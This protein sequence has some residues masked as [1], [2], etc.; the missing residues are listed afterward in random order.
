M[1]R[2]QRFD[3]TDNG[4]A[5]GPHRGSGVPKS[6]R[7][8]DSRIPPLPKTNLLASDAQTRLKAAD[9]SSWDWARS[10]AATPS[11]SCSSQ[12]RTSGVARSTTCPHS[13][14]IEGDCG[15]CHRAPLSIERIR[16]DLER[17]RVLSGRSFISR[18]SSF[19]EV[20]SSDGTVKS[21]FYC[22]E[23]GC[24]KSCAR[25]SDMARHRRSKHGGTT[26]ECSFPGCQFRNP[27][28]DRLIKHAREKHPLKLIECPAIAYVSSTN[29]E[30]NGARRSKSRDQVNPE[31]GRESSARV[32][33]FDQSRSGF[34]RLIVSGFKLLDGETTAP[35][36]HRPSQGI[37]EQR[38]SA[39]HSR[40]RRNASNN[41]RASK[42]RSR[43]LPKS[44][45]L[46]PSPCTIQQSKIREAIG[47]L[48]CAAVNHYANHSTRPVSTPPSVSKPSKSSKDRQ[49]DFD[50]R[51]HRFP[52]DTV[53]LASAPSLTLDIPAQDGDNGRPSATSQLNGASWAD[54]VRNTSSTK[55]SVGPSIND[56][57]R[58]NDGL[59][60][61]SKG[62]RRKLNGDGYEEFFVCIGHHRGRPGRDATNECE[63]T[64]KDYF[65]QL[66]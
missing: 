63:G 65:S 22:A 16:E 58:D 64:L 20:A 24:L 12:V 46:E 7:V 50:I 60:G 29:G 6:K 55:T 26:F 41:G 2:M 62:K 42:M 28:K 45:V 51:K 49:T 36:E 14:A 11:S 30:A 5:I 25:E 19:R 39:A 44:V 56:G 3:K 54:V 53:G 21:R 9:T 61:R 33:N 35:D 47:R 48:E 34:G 23:P 38:N 43:S 57:A 15:Q 17:D 40:S 4:K 10:N 18:E 8:S 52:P 27:R 1:R 66:E 59:A 37:D 31:A 13:R 32:Q